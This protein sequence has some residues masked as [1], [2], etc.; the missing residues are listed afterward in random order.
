PEAARRVVAQR[1][2]LTLERPTMFVVGPEKVVSDAVVQQLSAYGEV[3]RVSGESPVENAIALAR[4]RDP[5]TQFGWGMKKGQANVSLVNT[6]QWANAIGAFTFA[7]KGPQAP[8]LLTDS[9][10][11]LPG[12]LA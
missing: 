1:E 4:Y 10:E 9:S 6:D 7:A 2:K 12:P 11:H 8:L 5:E 3:K